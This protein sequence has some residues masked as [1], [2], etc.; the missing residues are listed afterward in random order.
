MY[1]PRFLVTQEQYNAASADE[2]ER[3]NYV[4]VPDAPIPLPKNF[5]LPHQERDSDENRTKHRPLN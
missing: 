4:V 5:C 1:K 3:F 2:R